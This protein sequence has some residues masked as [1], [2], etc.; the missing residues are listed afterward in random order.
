MY[1][2]IEM[3]ITKEARCAREEAVRKELNMVW[4]IKLGKR[5]K[6]GGNDD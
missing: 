3:Y 2:D 5:K 6:K 4:Y 1:L